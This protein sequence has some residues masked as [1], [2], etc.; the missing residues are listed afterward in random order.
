MGDLRELKK[1]LLYTIIRDCV[2]C[3][4]E[5][6]EECT[7][8]P[9]EEAY[10]VLK[11]KQQWLSALEMEPQANPSL[12]CHWCPGDHCAVAETQS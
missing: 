1:K 3:N 9:M 6:Q 10:C 4:S 7:Y 12:C 11:L 8:E 5:L 2:L